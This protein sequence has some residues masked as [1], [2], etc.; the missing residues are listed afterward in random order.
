MPGLALRLIIYRDNTGG[1]S[2]SKRISGSWGLTFFI[3]GDLRIAQFNSSSPAIQAKSR[4]TSTCF[5]PKHQ[6]VFINTD[7][8][9]SKP[10]QNPMPSMSKPYSNRVSPPGSH[11]KPETLLNNQKS[12]LPPHLKT[13]LLKPNKGKTSGDNCFCLEIIASAQT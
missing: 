2:S 11:P 1:G 5:P 9:H 6:L 13:T 10:F 4:S 12:T 7:G 8:R 3:C